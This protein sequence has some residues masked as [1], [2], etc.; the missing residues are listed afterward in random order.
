MAYDGIEV[1]IKLPATSAVAQSLIARLSA[2]GSSE[3][4]QLDEYFDD[5]RESYLLREPIE[6]WLSVRNRDGRTIMNHKRFFFDDRGRATHNQESE[7]L[8]D[9]VDT[10]I[11][12]LVS[13]GYTPLVTVE[14]RRV[15]GIVDGYQ[16][17]VDDVPGLGHFVEIEAVRA[18][19]NVVE[20]RAALEE[21]ARSLGLDPS[22]EDLRGY[23]YLL[24]AR[25]GKIQTS[26]LEP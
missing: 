19:G 7:V 12:L 21:Y 20:T 17:S 1:E 25:L 11:G 15:E 6:Q 9:T 26:E 10:A 22:T 24:L 14:K 4:H 18:E 16:L 2:A 8:A 5:P 23:P 13:L 3:V